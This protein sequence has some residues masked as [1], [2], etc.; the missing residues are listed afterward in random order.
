MKLVVACVGTRMPD[1]IAAG[2]NEY[3]R[4]MPPHLKPELHEVAGGGRRA[5]RQAADEAERLLA[6]V[7]ERC[8]RV[9]LDGSGRL[10]STE[11][12]ASRLEQ[13]QLEGDPVWLFIGGAEGLDAGLLDRCHE[14]WSLGPATW[15][16]MLVRVM[17][18]E[19]LYRAWTIQAGHPYHRA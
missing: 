1:W 18:A 7:P 5:G 4:R 13:W 6:A 15:P 9:A 2:W 14:R 16:H 17:V 8:R 10:W 12:L 19:Q 11:R 3:A